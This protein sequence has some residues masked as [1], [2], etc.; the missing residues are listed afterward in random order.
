MNET[1]DGMS[2]SAQ[3]W[4]DAYEAAKNAD[5]C[6]TDARE[7]GG[8][9]LA[10]VVVSVYEDHERVDKDED[11]L[12]AAIDALEGEVTGWAPEFL[13]TVLDSHAGESEDDLAKVATD[14]IEEQ[15]PGF[16]VNT[17][18]DLE[19]FARTYAIPESHIAG[20]TE[21]GGTLHYFDKNK[22]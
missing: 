6:A 18:S 17:I 13:R 20:V 4:K 16:P 21:G 10:A 9:E 14:Y 22:W 11:K 7:Q 8:G 12:Y 2:Y 15:W 3:E 1:L 5:W 19:A